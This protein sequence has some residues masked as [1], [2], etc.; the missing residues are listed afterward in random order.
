[1][2]VSSRQNPL[3]EEGEVS[4]EEEALF[5]GTDRGGDEAGGGGKLKALLAVATDFGRMTGYPVIIRPEYNKLMGIVDVI[6]GRFHQLRIVGVKATASP[7][8]S[9]TTC[10]QWRDGPAIGVERDVADE[11]LRL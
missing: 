6:P 7:P 10:R 2:R 3:P 1:L 8:V 11:D 5:C 9:E 4:R